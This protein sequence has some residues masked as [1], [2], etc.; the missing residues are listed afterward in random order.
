MTITKNMETLPNN[1]AF[2]E[3]TSEQDGNRV[4][5]EVYSTG[6]LTIRAYM[7]TQIAIGLAAYGNSDPDGD[8]MEAV[9]RADALIKQLNTEK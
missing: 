4:L 7:A 5:A 2:P 3:I 8:A 1:S 9:M 6:G